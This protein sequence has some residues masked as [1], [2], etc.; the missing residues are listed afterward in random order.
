MPIKIIKN[1]NCE[2]KTSLLSNSPVNGLTFPL[3]KKLM[4]VNIKF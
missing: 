1:T 4:N 3:K 2:F